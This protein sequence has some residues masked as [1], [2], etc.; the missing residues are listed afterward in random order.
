MKYTLLELVQSIMG[1]MS[2]DEINSI[3]D[4]PESLMVA[5]IVKQNF[6][7]LVGALDLPEHKNLFNLEASGDSE[8][9]CVMYLPE[10]ALEVFYVK[11]NRNTAADPDYYKLQYTD[12]ETFHQITN[13]MDTDLSNVETQT[14]TLDGSS[15]VFKLYNDRVPSRYTTT[16]DYTLLFDS[17][18]SDDDSTLVSSKTMA[19]GLLAPVFTMNNSYVPDLDSRQHQLLLNA[20]KAQAFIELKQVEN[21]NASR[22]ERKNFIRAQRTKSSVESTNE[23]RK[24]T[25]KTGMGR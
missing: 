4:T 17:Y 10:N 15:F 7:D 22:K 11:Y 18:D 23:Y 13:G 2:S 8:L 6:Y 16:D 21:P 25:A 1:S 9:P 5:D 12:F 19:L 24:Q 3:G 14:V 20:S